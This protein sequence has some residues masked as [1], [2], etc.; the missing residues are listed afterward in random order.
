MNP[1]R[2]KL[3]SLVPAVL[4]LS[5]LFAFA[6]P[7]RAVELAARP[8]PPGGLRVLFLGNSLTQAND[9][10]LVVKAL[11]EA[12][13]QELT[14]ETVAFP[15]ANLEDLW[16]EGSAL[17][18]IAQG[19]WDFVV[20]QQG[21]SSLPE[22]REHLRKWVKKFSRRIRAAGARPAVY[23][24][25]PSVD[26]ISFFDAVVE[27]YTLAAE[28]VRGLL[29][30]AGETWRAAWRRD[31]DLAL[32]GPD[33]FHP[34]IAGTYAVA[35]S[36]YGMFYL[37]STQGLPNRLELENGEVI[38]V[39]RPVARLLQQAADEANRTAGRP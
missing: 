4:A 10:P 1:V 22:S 25:W 8:I 17:A 23:M 24:V 15:N 3:L 26:R 19:D 21:P 5:L 20:M 32:Y 34:S 2:R 30:P 18:A 29:I 11:A 7:A 27:S 36:M 33:G 38:H 12:A 13:G 35:L 16:Y 39:P 14:V 28:D 6:G 9:L 31:P 37:R